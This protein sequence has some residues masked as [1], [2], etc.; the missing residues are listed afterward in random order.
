MLA[1]IVVTGLFF[2]TGSPQRRM[3]FV[4]IV[5]LAWVAAP[6]AI[7]ERAQFGLDSRDLNAISAG[8][9]ENIWLPLLPDIGDHLLFGQGL[10]AIMWT[11]AQ[12]LQQIYP[13]SL[14]HNAYLDLVLDVGL[15]GA[16]VVLAWYAYLWNGFRRAASSDPDPRFRALF[17]G[18]Q[19]ALVALCLCALSNDRLTPTAPACL[20]WVVAG[21]WLGRQAQLE[22]AGAWVPAAAKR[23]VAPRRGA[24]PA[25]PLVT[26]APPREVQA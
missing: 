2:L 6:A 20:L 22:R 24:V 10:Y 16:C 21:V 3:A 14:A 7:L 17:N 12:R 18:G 13:V 11:D 5:L 23:F 19:L 9:L 25:R 15:F 4:A 26:S 8:R 1:F